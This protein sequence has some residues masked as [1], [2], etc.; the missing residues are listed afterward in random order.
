MR[1]RF[2]HSAQGSAAS[3][4]ATWAP[5][6]GRIGR[7]VGCSRGT[8]ENE[9]RP[10]VKPGGFLHHVACIL[11]PRHCDLA[12]SQLSKASALD[13]AN[14]PCGSLPRSRATFGQPRPCARSVP[15]N[16]RVGI[17][18][19]VPSQPGSL[20]A[21]DPFRNRKPRTLPCNNL[22]LLPATLNPT[23]QALRIRLFHFLRCMVSSRRPP[24]ESSAH[25][26]GVA[27]CYSRCALPHFDVL[28]G[29][30][31]GRCGRRSY[32]SPWIDVFFRIRNIT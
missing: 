32:I 3:V 6:L 22:M 23:S 27:C 2:H 4:A 31:R 17:P 21:N 26:T 29:F 8:G 5:T 18:G 9:T 15:K 10:V 14:S 20:R 11:C 25:L 7:K 19:Q 16:A 13:P 24:L 28:F 12:G 1:F 30:G